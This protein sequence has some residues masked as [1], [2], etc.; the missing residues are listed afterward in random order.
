MKSMTP[1]AGWITK[2]EC[3]YNEGTK[4][5][6]GNEFYTDLREPIGNATSLDTLFHNSTSNPVIKQMERIYRKTLQTMESDC[7]R[8]VVLTV[9]RMTVKVTT[10]YVAGVFEKTDLT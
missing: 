5:R 1:T 4:G 9:D 10:N 3:R 2:Y 8:P 6:T 7:N